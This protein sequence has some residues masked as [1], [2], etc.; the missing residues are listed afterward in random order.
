MCRL[1]VLTPSY[2]PDL[3]LCRDLNRSVL[4]WMPE[5]VR[6][7]IIVPR[8]DRE[9]FRALQSPRTAIWTVDQLLPPRMF[10]VPRANVWLNLRR[11]YP[12]VRGWV[13]QQLVKLRAASQ[14]DADVLVL[15]D[16]DVRLVRP[17]T[18]DTFRQGGRLRF[19]REEAAVDEGMRRHL[20]WHRVARRLLG[21][22]DADS[23]LLPDYISAFNVWDRR[24]VSEMCSHIER[25]T[26]R[27][28][29]DALG[30]QLHISEF[31]LY[32][33][34]VDEVLGASANVFH[35]NSMLCHSYWDTTP[36]GP[37]AADEFV[38]ELG[39]EDVAIMI[40]A[41]SHTSLAVRRQALSHILPVANLGR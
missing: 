14:F 28:W 2:L 26:G 30:A 7:H 33:L 41:K 8:R 6:H 18:I 31:I 4:E 22:P 40:S 15:A 17:T 10:A 3:E 29:L 1:G 35:S 34:F 23:G 37:S 21:L 24:V 16:S 39:S 25:V 12:P 38:G 13:M 32:G 19:Y 27:S 5:D 20:I 9:A 36:L 11:P